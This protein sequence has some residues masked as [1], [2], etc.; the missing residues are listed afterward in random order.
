MGLV[1]SCLFW[2]LKLFAYLLQASI[3]GELVLRLEQSIKT[4]GGYPER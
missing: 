4:T 1:C 3:L 2:C